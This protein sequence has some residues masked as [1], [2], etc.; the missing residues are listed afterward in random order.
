MFGRVSSL[1]VVLK[2]IPLPE[3]PQQSMFNDDKEV[4]LRW[5]QPSPPIANIVY[6]IYYG[7]SI[8]ELYESEQHANYKFLL[9]YAIEHIGHIHINVSLPYARTSPYHHQ[10]HHRDY[11]PETVRRLFA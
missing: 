5:N 1:S 9:V 2:G 10:H 3:V 8:E 11:R 7:I 6:G 4:R